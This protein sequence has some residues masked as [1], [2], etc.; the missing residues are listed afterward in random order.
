[1]LFHGASPHDRTGLAA[2]VWVRDGDVDVVGGETGAQFA[3][4]AAFPARM[5]A[6]RGKY[7]SNQSIG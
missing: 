5:T 7:Q 6:A 1:L 3:V 2:H 4:L